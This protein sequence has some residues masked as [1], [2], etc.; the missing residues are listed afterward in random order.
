MQSSRDRS[1]RIPASAQRAMDRQMQRSM[2]AHLKKY[3]N[4]SG[5]VPQH[6]QKAIMQHM[7]KTMPAHLKKYSGAYVQQNMVMPNVTASVAAHNMSAAQP[8]VTSAAQFTP[9]APTS[10][11][12]Q[13]DMF[14]PDAA[15]VP[16]PD[17]N[18]VQQPAP[19]DPNAPAPSPFDHPVQPYD[20]IM[21]PEKPNRKFN[22][23]GANSSIFVRIALFGGGLVALLVIFSLVKGLVTKQPDLASFVTIAQDQQALIHL[24]NN[25]EDQKDLTSANQNFVATSSLTLPSNQSQIVSYL[26]KNG[27]KIESKTLVLRI[28]QST[29]A[30]LEAAAAAATYNQTFR[31]I[32]STKLD[33]YS[34]DLKQTYDQTS[35][36]KGKAILSDLY[37]Q[38]DLLKQQLEAN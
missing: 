27:H 29:D 24:I 34:S 21:S 13:P 16:A 22:L 31:D 7:E 2:P 30:Q 23:P 10:V 11:G 8:I 19:P 37:D 6:A 25:A 33:A 32:I 28:S 15:Q 38:T 18:N 20:F 36:T 4:G 26:A 9:H 14:H 12:S 5:Y 35:G 17:Q 3:Q 1:T